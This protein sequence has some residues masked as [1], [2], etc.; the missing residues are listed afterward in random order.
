MKTDAAAR[1]ACANSSI[2]PADGRL[3][4]ERRVLDPD[5]DVRRNDT[6]L[7]VARHV[8]AVDEIEDRVARAEIEDRPPPCAVATA[9]LDAARAAHQW[10]DDIMRRH[11]LRH[12]R[13]DE[14]RLAVFLQPRF[15]ERDRLDHALVG[16]ACAFAKREDAVLVEDE[17]FDLRIALEHRGCDLG[18]L[19]ARHHVGHEAHARPIDLLA[20]FG[21]VLLI[22]QADHGVGMGVIDEFVRQECMQQRL[23]RRI[24]RHRI[25]Q[26]GALDAHHVFVG[27]LI[28]C[29]ELMQRRKP[30][31]RQAGGLDHRHVG[32]RSP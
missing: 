11:L 13:A 27:H 2:L 30:H 12:L 16:F 20:E 29:Q 15:R 32:A 14:H 21:A 25:E 6:F 8:L 17:A 18:E 4:Q 26:I 9:I 24:W 19:E 28:A 5:G 22:D 23:D 31:R 10:R 1:V 7:A 3:E